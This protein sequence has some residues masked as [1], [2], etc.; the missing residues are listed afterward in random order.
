MSR[1]IHRDVQVQEA[2]ERAT[3]AFD[4]Q[5]PQLA[6]QYARQAL[7]REP[8]NL[9]ARLIQAQA[10]LAMNCPQ[11]ALDALDAAG[12]HDAMG[13]RGP[14]AGL[15]RAAALAR[16][17]RND[18]A[19]VQLAHVI[20]QCP[21]DDRAYRLLAQVCLKTG[22]G[23]GAIENL[24]QVQRLAPSDQAV[25]RVL[26]QLLDSDG[27]ELIGAADPASKLRLAQTFR[28]AKRD[29]DAQEIYIDLLQCQDEDGELWL[30]AGRLSDE[31]GADAQTIERLE[32]AAR[33]S[34]ADDVTVFCALAQAHMH[35]GRFCAAG[36]RWWQVA[37]RESACVM[38]W[39]GLLVCALCCNRKRAAH[40]A[41]HN[42]DRR[43]SKA[44][45]RALLANLWQHAAMG[46]II[47]PHDE[48]NPTS[49]LL[50]DRLLD[51]AAA[52]LTDHAAQHPHRADTHY[53][54]A[55]CRDG[56]GHE[57]AAQQHVDN[58]L[59]INPN[60]QAARSLADRLE[61]PASRAA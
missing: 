1:F 28:R 17:D 21:D 60:Y 20:A 57:A 50:L 22:D 4:A 24:R 45:R 56:L 53:H 51:S 9:K 15:L 34:A 55:V 5:L 19:R 11:D 12:Y 37:R 23:N 36:H 54:L 42:L 31:L 38:A 29:R 25:T 44:E 61:T 40:Y 27:A 46:K 3:T 35:A 8:H 32:H 14:Q 39:A 13:A 18:L 6:I 33:L 16:C 47:A 49:A 7:D 26:A 30:E 48:Q 41:Q 43:S 52:A 58:A 2:L 59:R 10:Q